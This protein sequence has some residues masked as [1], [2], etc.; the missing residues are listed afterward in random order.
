MTIA[1]ND[2]DTQTALQVA[3]EYARYNIPVFPCDPKTKKPLLAS[4]I[5]ENGN[6]IPKSGGLY[7]ATTDRETII[8]WWTKHP[9]AMIG[10]P[11]GPRSGYIV[12]DVDNDPDNGI[13]GLFELKKL[14]DQY[15]ALPIT[16]K[17]ITP[18]G[19][20]HYYFKVP[21]GVV[22][23]NS[24]SSIAPG[25]DVRGEGGYII[26][27]GSK[28]V[29]GRRYICVNTLDNCAQLPLHLINLATKRGGLGSKAHNPSS[30]IQKAANSNVSLSDEIAKVASTTIGGRNDALYRCAFKLGK[31]GFDEI[32]VL[33]RLTEAC[34]ENGL[35]AE[36]GEQVITDIIS[37]AFSAGQAAAASD[38]VEGDGE[39]EEHI[40]RLNKDYFVTKYGSDVLVCSI[41]R[42][43]T[44][45]RAAV[46]YSFQAF[47]RL[48]S[49][50]SV[51]R[52]GKAIKLGK[53]W[54]EHPNRR[55]YAGISFVPNGPDVL[56][57][58]IKN[59][60][61][62]FAVNPQKGNCDLILRHIHEVLANGNDAYA[63]YI[64]NYLA[65]TVQNPDKQAEVALIFKGSEGTGKGLLGRLIMDF[66][67]SAA[68]HISSSRHLVGNFNAHLDGTV[69][70][71]A[72]EAFWAGDK[73]ARGTFFALIT[74]PFI[75]IERK[76]ID[77]KQVINRLHIVMATNED[78]VV[79]AE[80]DSRR[81][82]VF[83]VSDK[84]KQKSKYFKPI[85][86]QIDQGGREAF[87]FDLLNR[88]IG[89]FHPRQIVKTAAFRNQVIQSL[90]PLETFWLQLIEE[91]H[92][93]VHHGEAPKNVMFTHSV[94]HIHGVLDQLRRS[95]PRLKHT[96]DR[97][98]AQFLRQKGCESWRGYSR[99]GWRLPN[100]KQARV[101]WE[102]KYGKWDW[103]NDYEDWDTYPESAF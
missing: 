59:L 32:E 34:L 89:D 91:G 49:N 54:L 29:D 96:T 72:D 12:I 18:R 20:E 1:L 53:F 6:K 86:E 35:L 10:I 24:A 94:G 8:K 50:V 17:V 14:E 73:A 19:G 68:M 58:N 67:G 84:Y 60:W 15:G 100:L 61:L 43:E 66:F 76:G 92:I 65:W 64:L 16:G 11:T 62:G 45:R 99:R 51:W 57:G 90:G 97:Q 75:T 3:L 78:W 48:Y 39:A 95:D 23:K 38:H 4:E 40:E 88:E 102:K 44:G 80:Y 13:D 74:E 82:A 69:M 85:Y 77:A 79:P 26:A 9:N 70:L 22:I 71:F 5:D 2:V 30:T 33:E 47:E 87:L 63:D 27:P 36:D 101:D 21:Q 46:Y 55:Q 81:Y 103:P 56:P 25:I 93:P 7:Q 98:M 42:D 28:R 31:A 83:E 41:E 52:N 37:R